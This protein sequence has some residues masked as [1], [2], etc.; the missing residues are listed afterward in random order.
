M[1][2]S[3]LEQLGWNKHFAE[4]A[5]V[6]PGVGLI[7]GRV[8]VH[9]GDYQVMTAEQTIRCHPSGAL[10]FKAEGAHELPVIGDWVMIR[11]NLGEPTGVIA[12]CLP[13]RTS[14]GRKIPGNT[15]EVQIIAANIDRAFL[16]SG[17][18]GDLNL[19]RLE[20]YLV[21]VRESGAEPII[22]LNKSDI[23]DWID[24][25]RAL[26][27]STAPGVRVVIMS[28]TTG[29]GMDEL[30]QL[31]E[32]GSTGALL[33]SSGVGKSSIVNKLLGD[34]RMRTEDVRETDGR[35]RHTTTHRELFF[36]PSGGMLIDTPGLRE[37]QLWG[38]GAGI[39]NAF[40]DIETLALECRFSNCHHETEPGCAIRGAIEREELDPDRLE[41]YRKLTREL[42]HL[43]QK[44][45]IRE[46]ITNKR[47]IVKLTV[48]NRR[49]NRHRP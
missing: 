23:C 33:G 30:R 16:V 10:K 20:R 43:R 17:L 47:R 12:G 15:T 6:F 45:D 41:N 19:P 4:A 44:L 36:L 2:P 1:P 40:G 46:R 28:A 32:P 48:E 34:E 11:T 3:Q 13:R 26:V 22:I 42:S 18:D 37:V 9:K 29:K 21:L 25:A 39:E 31:T 8:I 38:E 35:G 14:F 49:K 24:D 27:E 7:P 5:E